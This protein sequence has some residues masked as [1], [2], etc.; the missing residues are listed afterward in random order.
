MAVTVEFLFAQPQQAIAL[1]ISCRLARCTSASI[2]VGFATEDGLNAIAR[3]IS[4][5]PT[6]LQTFILGA[7]TYRGY[8]VLE[9]LNADGVPSDRL[10]VHL[11]H[12]RTQGANGFVKFHPMMHS[13]IFLL[14]FP[15]GQSAAFVGS[16]NLTGFA[17]NGMNGEAG[18]LI[19]GL[20]TDP[21][22]Q[23]I[24]DHIAEARRQ[25]ITYNA[26]MKSAL[27]W[28]TT[29][30]LD[31][32]RKEVNIDNDS[33]EAQKTFVILAE[34]GSSGRPRTGE[35]VYFEIP[36]GLPSITSLASE[37]H[38][39]VFDAL[40]PSP[41]DALSRLHEASYSLFCR[42]QGLELQ[43]GGRELDAEWKISSR[44][45]PLITPTQKPFRPTPS[46]DMQQVR[47]VVR[48]SVKGKYKYLFDQKDRWEP[49]YDHEQEIQSR[50][51]DA[52]VESSDSLE[53]KWTLVRGL[54][55]LPM[56][57]KRDYLEALRQV[58]PEAGNYILLSPRRIDLERMDNVSNEQ[59]R[60][61]EPIE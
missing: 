19:E 43:R 29:Q 9:R 59:D 36:S 46:A 27:A 44:A 32:L 56:R 12:T 34:S 6:K 54:K 48:R 33:E 3:D 52:E 15:D 26:D 4:Y 45:S 41:M 18:V 39:F 20:S 16:H 31:G 28:W 7:G 8:E 50:T 5:S 35:R 21:E 60:S 22:F 55:R 2:V 37:V 10:F 53:A 1:M 25:A 61:G 49:V 58:S 14:D 17:M 30:Y 13:K 57:G 38:I 23:K 51:A 42:T 11:G 40:P 24:R 47:V